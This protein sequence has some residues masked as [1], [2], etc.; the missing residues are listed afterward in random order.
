[1]ET[2]LDALGVSLA[3]GQRGGLVKKCVNEIRRRW[4]RCVG[5]LHEL[6]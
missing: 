1:M 2:L 5:S 4:R 3:L 6:R